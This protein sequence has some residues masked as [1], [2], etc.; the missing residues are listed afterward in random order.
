MPVAFPGNFGKEITDS[1]KFPSD[2]FEDMPRS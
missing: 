2:P 1:P